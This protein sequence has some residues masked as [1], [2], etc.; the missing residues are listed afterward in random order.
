MCD[1]AA[2]IANELIEKWESESE[3][4]EYLKENERGQLE[5]WEAVVWNPK[6]KKIEDLPEGYQ[7]RKKDI[8][9]KKDW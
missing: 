6:Y 1:G 3:K 4:Q 2:F 8:D 9:W 5:I 7:V